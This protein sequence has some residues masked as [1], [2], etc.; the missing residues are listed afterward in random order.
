M[1]IKFLLS[2][3]GMF[4]AYTTNA[5]AVYATD[6]QIAVYVISAPEGVVHAIASPD[7]VG[8]PSGYAYISANN[9][10]LIAMAMSASVNNRR[11]GVSFDTNAVPQVV[12]THATTPCKVVSI[13]RTPGH[14]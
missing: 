10:E 9:K 5:F 1:R 14:G 3:S 4:L 8:C 7:L 11:V 6:T 2:L 13:W 12:A